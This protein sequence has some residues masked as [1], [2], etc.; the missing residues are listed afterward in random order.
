MVGKRGERGK[1]HEGFFPNSVDPFE[2]VGGLLVSVESLVA[3]GEVF[4][5]LS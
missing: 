1:Y 5:M 2:L 4:S 3:G